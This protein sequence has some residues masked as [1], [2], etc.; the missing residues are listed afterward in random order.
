VTI[1][2]KHSVNF[3]WHPPRASTA[4]TLPHC[5]MFV[6]LPCMYRAWLQPRPRARPHISHSARGAPAVL[7]ILHMPSPHAHSLHTT[8]YLHASRLPFQTRLHIR[9]SA[10]ARVPAQLHTVFARCTPRIL[11]SPLHPNG[12]VPCPLRSTLHAS[13]HHV[14]RTGQIT[15]ASRQKVL[16]PSGGGEQDR[17][18]PDNPC[19]NHT[20]VSQGR[21][22]VEC[23][24]RTSASAG[25]P[26][27][28]ARGGSG[29]ITSLP[30][31]RQEAILR[32]FVGSSRQEP[33]YI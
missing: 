21:T 13:A 17:R 12:H 31:Y 8:S 26:L 3:E 10:R 5:R 29:P 28:A 6:S 19:V 7:T 20:L 32:P 2:T 25:P 4:R 24:T 22:A 11:F 30:R 1:C 16:S 27:P 9:F 18:R 33:C 14:Q 15:S 23:T